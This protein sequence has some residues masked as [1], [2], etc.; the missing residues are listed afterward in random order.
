MR[1]RVAMVKELVFAG[2]SPEQALAAMGLPQIDHT[3]IPS[4]Q[5]QQ[6]AQL[7]PLNPLSAYEVD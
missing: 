4:T 6:L 1:E 2:F 7:D 3:G 5:L